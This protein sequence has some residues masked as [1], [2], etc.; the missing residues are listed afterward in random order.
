MRKKKGK[1]SD[2]GNMNW[3][4]V[5]CLAAM[6]MLFVLVGMN[7]HTTNRSIPIMPTPHPWEGADYCIDKLENVPQSTCTE[8]S[9]WRKQSKQSVR[10]FF[11]ELSFSST[12]KYVVFVRKLNQFNYQAEWFPAREWLDKVP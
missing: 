2:R 8:F 1:P 5:L 10:K 11:G 12:I 4:I 7:R 6:V 9:G 3:F